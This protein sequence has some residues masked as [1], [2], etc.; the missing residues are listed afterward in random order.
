MTLIFMSYSTSL[1]KEKEECIIQTMLLNYWNCKSHDIVNNENK[2]LY[3]EIKQK[4]IVF[5]N[6]IIIEIRFIF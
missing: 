5:Q 1:N 3:F 2:L 6:F 4:I